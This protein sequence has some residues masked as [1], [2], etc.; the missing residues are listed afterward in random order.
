MLRIRNQT[1]FLMQVHVAGIRA[2]WIKPFRT[3]LFKGLKDG[4]HKVFANSEYGS[5]SW[6]PRSVWVPGTLLVT[7]STAT[8]LYS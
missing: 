7:P 5:G 1:P 8:R 4:N 2:G 3:A 6:G